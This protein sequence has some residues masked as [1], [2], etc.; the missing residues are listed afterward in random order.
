MAKKG[1]LFSILPQQEGETRITKAPDF[2]VIGG[3]K[4]SHEKSQENSARLSERL[5]KEE[6]ITPKKM[7]D[8]A[9]DLGIA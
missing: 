8:I 3:D 7:L 4:E 1:H 5:N 2:T 6:N 9:H